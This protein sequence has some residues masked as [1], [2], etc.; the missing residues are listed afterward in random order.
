MW[1]LPLLKLFPDQWILP[2]RQ[3]V[4]PW[5]VVLVAT[6][7]RRAPPQPHQRFLRPPKRQEEAIW[8]MR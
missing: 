8:A 6:A 4:E 3:T 2:K 7:A 1:P 5:Q